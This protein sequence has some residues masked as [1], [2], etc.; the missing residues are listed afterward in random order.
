MTFKL[1]LFPATRILNWYETPSSVNAGKC[2]EKQE[3]K[4]YH[5]S[6]RGSLTAVANASS[7]LE[8]RVGKTKM[9]LKLLPVRRR[10]DRQ[11]V[12]VSGGGSLLLLIHSL[13]VW[14]LKDAYGIWAPPLQTFPVGVLELQISKATFRTHRKSA[15]KASLFSI[16]KICYSSPSRNPTR[17]LWPVDVLETEGRG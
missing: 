15:S 1:V 13:Y 10:G 7:L 6:K 4:G 5:L 11:M 17:F 8:M 2:K 14:G 16:W 9:F 12:P 3:W